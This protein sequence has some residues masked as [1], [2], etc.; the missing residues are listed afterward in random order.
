MT[1]TMIC[2]YR[3]ALDPTPTQQR[4]LLGH[5]GAARVAHNWG[6]AL[7]KAVLDQRAAERSYG[8]TDHAL[9]PSLSWSTYSLRTAWNAA[10]HKVAP[11]WAENSK[12]AYTSGLD[13]L[14]R[15]LD[16]W[17]SSRNGVRHGPKV[18]FPRFKTRHTSIPSVRFTTGTIRVSADRHHVTLPRLREIKT[19]ESTRK[20]TRRLEAGTARILSA[21]VHRDSGRWYCSFTVKVQRA[22]RTPQHPDATVGVDLG[23]KSLAILSDGPPVANPRHLDASLRRAG[24]RN[25]TMARRVGPHDPVTKRRREPSSRWLRAQRAV[26]AAHTRVP[27]QHRDGPPKLTTRIAAEYG[28]VMVKDLHVA[29]MLHN[30]R[31]A[32]HVADCSWAELRRQ[33]DYKTR[34]HSSRLAVADQWFA[35]SKTCSECGAVRA[36]LTLSQRTFV[37]TACGT[38][39]DRDQNAARNL[40]NLASKL[41]VAGSGPETT[42]GRGADR[43]T[44]LSGQVAVKRQPGAAPAGQTGTGRPQG[45][46]ADSRLT[47]AC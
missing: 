31:L 8:I 44:H 41:D 16:A 9:T 26:A 43:K 7:V 32:R 17:S 37:C 24:R 21:T 10:K 22:E 4:A 35:S 19:H 46:P 39:L 5:A 30:R 45:R 1:T 47:H 25:R 18:G 23:I 15:G 40:R 2:A 33:L 36:K 27:H 28:T 11:W 38:V 34:W 29:G 20:L 6:L 14:A 12:E 3:F 42:N 13:R